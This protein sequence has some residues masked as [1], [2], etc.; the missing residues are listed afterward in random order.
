KNRNEGQKTQPT[1][2]KACGLIEQRAHQGISFRGLLPNRSPNLPSS[3]ERDRI[4]QIKAELTR[5]FAANAGEWKRSE[6]HTSELQSPD[7]HS[8]PTRRSSDLKE[9]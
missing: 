8:L 4:S 9:S 6:E 3:M 7:Q 1:P 2:Q 5:L